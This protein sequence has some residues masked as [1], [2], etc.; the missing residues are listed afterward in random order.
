[1]YIKEFIN[2]TA[3]GVP[4]ALLLGVLVLAA[5]SAVNAQT[6]ANPNVAVADKTQPQATVKQAEPAPVM[7]D[8]K[9]ITIGMNMDDVK[10]KLGK[11]ERSDDAGMY[12]ELS[13]GEMM[14]LRFDAD[15][16]VSLAAV[17]YV[18]KDAAAPQAADVFGADV[19]VVPNDKGVIY[20]M[21]R[22][23]SAGYWMAYSRIT[24]DGGPMTTVTMQ[25]IN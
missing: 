23:P 8:L 21:V 25:K 1:M 19:T 16:H 20:K 6:G 2:R 17:T 13:N 24:V 11:P 9:G 18:G 7:N 15:K 10:Q 4:G 5:A 3:A 12:F 22:Y 14:Q